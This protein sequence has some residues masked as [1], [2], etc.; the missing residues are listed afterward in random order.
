MDYV[1]VLEAPRRM[2]YDILGKTGE[3]MF[4]S[5]YSKDDQQE[6]LPKLEPD[7]SMCTSRVSS[8]RA[9]GYRETFC[10]ARRANF[11]PIATIVV[12]TLLSFLGQNICSAGWMLTGLVGTLLL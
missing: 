4:A 9:Y 5:L 8:A 2:D 6:V 11:A 7:M 12:Q 10:A 3:N 1:A